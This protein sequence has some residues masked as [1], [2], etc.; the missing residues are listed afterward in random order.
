MI[1][2]NKSFEGEASGADA[3]TLEA[4]YLEEYRDTPLESLLVNALGKLERYLEPEISV[5][6]YAPGQ[7]H[8]E[9]D[10]PAVKTTRDDQI[11]NLRLQS[12]NPRFLDSDGIDNNSIGIEGFMSLFLKQGYY[13]E[14]SIGEL[15]Q[16]LLAV[17]YHITDAKIV[18]DDSEDSRNDSQGSTIRRGAYWGSPIYIRETWFT[19]G[20]A[21]D[22][23]HK[24]NGAMILGKDSGKNALGAFSVAD[25]DDI[26]TAGLKPE[27]LEDVYRANHASLQETLVEIQATKI[28]VDEVF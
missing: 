1:N 4:E 17:L 6:F 28:A 20:E 23:G 24:L 5:G 14:G 22:E 7:L 26:K 16:E 25:C 8:D 3:I 9:G 18:R 2:Q 27:I 10:I 19:L 12:P 21:G 13:E 15:G 11:T